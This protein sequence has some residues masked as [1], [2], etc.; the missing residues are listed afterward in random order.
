[1]RFKSLILLV[2]LTLFGF[3]QISLG[4]GSVGG[5]PF[6]IDFNL[7]GEQRRV[8]GVDASPD[9]F[10]NRR[11]TVGGR[12]H[13]FKAYGNMYVSFMASMIATELIY[14]SRQHVPGIMD[15]E[16]TPVCYD[17]L[18]QMLLDPGMNLGIIAMTFTSLELN[19]RLR[20]PLEKFIRKITS[21]RKVDTVLKLSQSVLQTLTMGA[22]MMV[23]TTVS[24]TYNSPYFGECM[25]E[26]RKRIRSVLRVDNRSTAA[27][28]REAK[29]QA[30]IA[31]EGAM[32]ESVCD[33]AWNHFKDAEKGTMSEIYITVMSLGVSTAIS[34]GAIGTLKL[35]GLTLL[36]GTPAGIAIMA[37]G[38]PV[39][40]FTIE[41]VDRYLEPIIR[42]LYHRVRARNLLMESL[43]EIDTSLKNFAKTNDFIESYERNVKC[44]K[45]DGAYRAG[46][47][48]YP[49]CLKY[50]TET[51]RRFR[52]LEAIQ[53]YKKNI[54]YHSESQLNQ[55]IEANNQWV[56]KVSNVISSFASFQKIME[57]IFEIREHLKTT[58]DH[59]LEDEYNLF[60]PIGKVKDVLPL[61]YDPDD[62]LLLTEPRAKELAKAK[63]DS[64]MEFTPSTYGKPSRLEYPQILKIYEVINRVRKQVSNS[65]LVHNHTLLNVIHQLH[66]ALHAGDYK[67]IHIGLWRLKNFF[68]KN[69]LQIINHTNALND[70]ATASPEDEKIMQE[71]FTIPVTGFTSRTRY[72]F[73]EFE[74]AIG[75][76]VPF[77]NDL[78][79]NPN[80]LDGPVR[81]GIQ[82]SSDPRSGLISVLPGE[83]NASE[84]TNLPAKIISQ[85]ACSNKSEALFDYNDGRESKLLFPNILAYPQDLDCHYQP[86]HATLDQ[87]LYAQ[88]DY[89]IDPSGQYRELQTDPALHRIYAYRGEETIGLLETLLD[90]NVPLRWNSYEEFDAYWKNVLKPQFLTFLMRHRKEYQTMITAYYVPT[91][92]IPSFDLPQ[93]ERRHFHYSVDQPITDRE[94]KNRVRYWSVH[95]K[96]NATY[97]AYS[98]GA[99]ESLSDEIRTYQ[100]IAAQL[101]GENSKFA[102]YFTDMLPFAKKARESVVLSSDMGEF[103]IDSMD[104]VQLLEKIAGDPIFDAIKKEQLEEFGKHVNEIGEL[105]KKL[106]KLVAEDYVQSIIAD[107]FI[108]SQRL[109]SGDPESYPEGID[110]GL[111]QGRGMVMNAMLKNLE[112]SLQH[113]IGVLIEKYIGGDK[114][115]YV[116]PDR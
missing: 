34:A 59:E 24:S 99:Y 37:I 6:D 20:G 52:L 3:S 25:A 38:T 9:T 58:P 55:F 72:A 61:Y 67:R 81:K 69:H 56:Q 78:G 30:S 46:P 107:E 83:S 108:K 97:Y 92:E 90:P 19:K 41:M 26:H 7:E 44:L 35:V 64:I 95:N 103:D 60:E 87:Y 18:V 116:P 28:I 100:Y 14:C 27:E 21:P 51:V 66:K 71:M 91:K 75:T 4:A 53:D 11:A 96:S 57:M 31:V 93:K 48:S 85:L 42:A 33:K 65:T 17:Q 115:I 10:E 84:P 5:V 40:M 102:Q 2:F 47:H 62:L 111:V 43:D 101:Y 94:L 15:N 68:A 54:S 1:P 82:L 36:A 50:E 74:A 109:W 22:G 76:Q 104:H 110:F 39:I 113:F 79:Y 49:R 29:K 12:T 86:P 112:Q 8:R 89:L 73:Y 105:G 80:K 16:E 32:K 23:Q 70:G 98:V 77:L 114:V 45:W 88:S 13:T 106:S 63:G